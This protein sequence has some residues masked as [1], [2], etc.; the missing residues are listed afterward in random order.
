MLPH[1]NLLRIG[2]TILVEVTYNFAKFL[3]HP[4]VTVRVSADGRIEEEVL[5]LAN[6][7]VAKSWLAPELGCEGDV[8]EFVEG[9]RGEVYRA[10]P[11][12]T[13]LRFER[14]G[15]GFFLKLH[16]GVGWP[17][18]LKNLLSFRL[19]ILSAENERAA[20][21][22]LARRGVDT[23]K[24]AGY[25]KVGC[26]P[27]ST[28]SFLIT[29]EI[30]NAPSLEEVTADWGE[31]PPTPAIKW[32]FI[33]EVARVARQMHEAGVNHRDFYLCHFLLCEENFENPKLV[34]I[35]LHRA[36]IRKAVPVRWRRKDL[37][38]LY[39][40]AAHISLTQKDFLRFICEYYQRPLAELLVQERG[41]LG[42]I[43]KAGDKLRAKFLRKYQK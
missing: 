21:D 30:A 8:F 31:Q 16:R 32:T 41:E 29:H 34:L 9:L 43:K 35:D 24:A 38:A 28:R 26:N 17:E 19:P 1:P 5:S 42:R 40:S 39:S 37:A 13:T 2:V 12:R 27:A 6:L 10:M 11:D 4:A 22:L 36:Q 14:G 15:S 25:G 20:I 3:W 7:C 18:I 33:R 23:M